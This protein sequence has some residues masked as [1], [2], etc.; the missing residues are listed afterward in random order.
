MY[1][2]TAKVFKT[3]LILENPI[4]VVVAVILSF[5][6]EFSEIKLNLKRTY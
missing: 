1:L 2:F 5:V 3:D 6:R 4:W